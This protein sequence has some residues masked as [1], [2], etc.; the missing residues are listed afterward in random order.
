MWTF[1]LR[2]AIQIPVVLLAVITITFF[3][4]RAAPGG[5]FSSER[6]LPRHIEANLN[7]YYGFDRPLLEQYG[8]YLVQLCQGDLG[9]ST[10]YE[11][12]TVNEII[13]QSFPVSLQLGLAAFCLS[14]IIGLPLGIYSAYRQNSVFDYSLMSIAMIGICLPTFVLGPLLSY[15]FALKFGWFNSS[16]WY[17]PKDIVLPAVTLGLY[18]AAYIARLSRAGMLEV[19]N[20][21]FIRTARAKGLSEW[22]VVV[23]HG[24]KIAIRPVVSYLGPALA[25]MVSGSFVVELIYDV[26]GLGRFFVLGAINQ[27]YSLVLGT[28]VFFALLIV[29]FNLAV[30][31]ILG[32]L[33]PKQ[34]EL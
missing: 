6:Q 26:P 24:V 21:D 1:I 20:Q 8:A 10:K 25:G 33:N 23:T 3:M 34:R 5:P 29:I 15:F 30:D 17:E 13:G 2:R 19:M 31:V 32:L 28:V 27:D 4:V 14:V 12:L 18:F 16:G 9:P 22:G 7:A 11:G